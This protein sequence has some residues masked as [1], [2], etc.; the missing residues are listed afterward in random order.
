[1]SNRGPLIVFSIVF[2]IAY[3]LCFYF[4]VALFK[5]YPLVAEFH[6]NNQP[7]ELGP[8][9]SWYGWMAVA[10]LVG[11]PIAFLLPRSWSNRLPTSYAWVIPMLVLVAVLIYEKRWFV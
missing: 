9:I 6:I 7:K 11:L 4:N 3:T 2:V 8:P 1:M 10:A 5:Y